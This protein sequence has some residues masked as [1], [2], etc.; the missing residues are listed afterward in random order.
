MAEDY[1]KNTPEWKA[2]NHIWKSCTSE[3]QKENMANFELLSKFIRNYHGLRQSKLKDKDEYDYLNGVSPEAKQF[4]IKMIQ[5][6]ET[7][8]YHSIMA[9]IENKRDSG[10]D[11]ISAYYFAKIGAKRPYLSENQPLV[12]ELIESCWHKFHAC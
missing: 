11:D 10:I 2:L 12:Q 1:I 6:G 3:Q 4:V 5:Q 9:V 8:L 7:N